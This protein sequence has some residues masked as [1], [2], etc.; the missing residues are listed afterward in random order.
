MTYIEQKRR[1]E[2]Q[3]ACVGV[4]VGVGMGVGAHNPIS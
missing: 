2:A 1:L 4:G 3:D